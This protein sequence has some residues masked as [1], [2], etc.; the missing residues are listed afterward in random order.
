M[1]EVV[2][3]GPAIGRDDWGL[4]RSVADRRLRLQRCGRCSRWWYPPGPCCPSCLSFEWSWT[5]V[6]GEGLVVSW[7]TFHRPYF[8]EIETP[9]TIVVGQALEGPLLP[10]DFAY[11]QLRLKVGLKVTLEYYEA[12]DRRTDRPFT[13]FRWRPSEHS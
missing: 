10:T 13:Q 12:R 3:P 11:D 7:A 5:L 4:W 8:P 9:H 2:R 1:P 6:S